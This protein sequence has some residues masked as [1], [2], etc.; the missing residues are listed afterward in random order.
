MPGPAVARAWCRQRGA[1][2]AGR[3]LVL[4]AVVV[5][6]TVLAT[7]GPTGETPVSGKLTVACADSAVPLLRREARTFQALYPQARVDVVPTDSRGALVQLFD[8]QAGVAVISRVPT[9][10]ERQAGREAEA[11]FRALRIAID[12]VAFI[13]HRRNR[14]DSL[15][16]AQVGGLLAG[17]TSTWKEVG[18]DEVPVRPMLRD[19][20]SGTY[21]AVRQQVLEG[22]DFGRGLLCSTSQEVASRVAADP[23]AIG[24]VGLAWIDADVKVLRV[25]QSAAGPFVAARAPEI[26]LN[27]YPVCRPIVACQARSLEEAPLAAGFISFLTSTRGQIVVESEGLV[28]DTVPQRTV[29]LK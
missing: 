7:C 4:P 26:Y 5:G 13:V 18:G 25:A 15:T 16:V 29:E 8:G 22:A 10:D 11:E 24:C 14:V 2:A 12:A 17:R 23:G 27:R 21:Q 20:N 9:D 6:T 1:R 19:R 28:P 3:A